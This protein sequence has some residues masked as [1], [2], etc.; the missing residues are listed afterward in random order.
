MHRVS[1]ETRLILKPRLFLSRSRDLINFSVLAVPTDYG[2]IPTVA[3][4][5]IIRGLVDLHVVSITK[6]QF[7]CYDVRTLEKL[8]RASPKLSPL[9]FQTFLQVH[10]FFSGSSGVPRAQVSLSVCTA[11]LPAA[12]KK[13]RR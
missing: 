10:G 2:G 4:A 9:F 13:K 8:V 12:P 7:L 6:S 3:T 1:L 5:L 11:I